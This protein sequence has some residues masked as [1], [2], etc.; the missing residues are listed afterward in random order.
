M[1]LTANPPIDELI[2]GIRTI[3]D[4]TLG[5]LTEFWDKEA[6]KLVAL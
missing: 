3:Q 4:K 6:A 5:D 2:D 1:K